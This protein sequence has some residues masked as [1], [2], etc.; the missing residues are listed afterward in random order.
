MFKRVTVL[1]F[2]AVL[3]IAAGGCALIQ[4]PPLGPEAL[5]T[6]LEMP[7][8]LG[9]QPGEVVPLKLKVGNFFTDRL[10]KLTLRGRPAYDFVVT[11]PDGTEVWSWLRGQAIEK[12]LEQ[13][14]L[15]PGEKLE[16][17]AEWQQLD[18]Q[19]KPVPSGAYF[20]RGILRTKPQKLEI[21]PRQI[22]IGSFMPL[23]PD[24]VIPS[25]VRAGERV[26]LKLKVKNRTDRPVV[27]WGGYPLADFIVTKPDGTEVW[28]WSSGKVFI[29][30][31]LQMVL[32]PGEEKEYEESWQQVDNDCRL[33]SPGTYLV[34]G[35]FG[36]NWANELPYETE[37]EPQPLVISEAYGSAT[38][39][40]L[41]VKVARRVPAF[42]GMFFDE[43][44]PNILYVYL[45]D[46]TQ[47]AEAEAAIMEI[48][49]SYRPDIVQIVWERG[50][51]VLTGQYSYL[52]LKGW[53]TCLKGVKGVI[54]TIPT[55][56]LIDIDETKNRLMIRFREMEEATL[57]FVE[58]ELRWLG[59]PREAVI[60][61]GAGP[62][63]PLGF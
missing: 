57:R 11:G 25:E 6:W 23:K 17:A 8:V 18:N 3:A 48:F 61:V 29:A 14:I 31:G 37:T 58:Q 35:I 15:N 43:K 56:T 1:G 16:F 53:H 33:V 54:S 62:T 40:D 26:P 27:L 32:Q 39:D 13:K 50:T 10:I 63:T 44:N 52:Q 36:F 47:K 24:L 4:R 7:L 5:S 22:I 34:R 49:T 59:I 19:G 51:R 9:V 12:I 28:R 20:V 41:F 21:G 2:I 55:V 46:P 38:I 60:F 30:I 45:L 42:G